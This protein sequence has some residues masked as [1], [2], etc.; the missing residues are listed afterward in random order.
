MKNGKLCQ[1]LFAFEA[2]IEKTASYR[3]T[4]NQQ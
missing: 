1:A 3:K 2:T 4:A